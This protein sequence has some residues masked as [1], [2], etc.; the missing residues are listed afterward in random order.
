MRTRPRRVALVH[1]RRDEAHGAVNL[2]DAGDLDAR[3]LTDADRAEPR[4]H[5]LGVELHLALGDDAEHGLGGARGVAADARHAAADD[6]V[7][8]A[9]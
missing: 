9:P 1:L 3:R 7:G 8:R 2:A 6:A 5:H 4:L